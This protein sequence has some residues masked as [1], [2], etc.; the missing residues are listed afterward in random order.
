MRLSSLKSLVSSEPELG[1]WDLFPLL[2]LLQDCLSPAPRCL[3]SALVFFH[4]TP[5]SWSGSGWLLCLLCLLCSAGLPTSQSSSM[6]LELLC[7][8]PTESR[9]LLHTHSRSYTVVYCTIL[10]NTSIYHTCQYTHYH[11]PLLTHLRPIGS[12]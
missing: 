4:H 7:H 1:L 5:L 3:P 11:T 9:V 2:L 10:L 8:S 6:G 12:P